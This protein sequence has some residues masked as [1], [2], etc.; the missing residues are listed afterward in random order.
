MYYFENMRWISN[1]FGTFRSRDTSTRAVAGSD[2]GIAA[3]TTR[4]NAAARQRNV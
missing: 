4:L 2:G 1:S 3:T